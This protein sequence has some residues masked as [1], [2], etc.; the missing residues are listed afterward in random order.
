MGRKRREPPRG[1]VGEEQATV[2]GERARKENIPE[3]NHETHSV[4]CDRKDWGERLLLLD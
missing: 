2:P 4:L 1:R 3:L